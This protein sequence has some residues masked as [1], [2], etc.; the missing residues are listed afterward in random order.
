L[1]RQRIAPLEPHLKG[2]KHLLVV[3]AGKMAA[4]PIEALTDRYTVSY[5]PSASIFARRMEDHRP[6][7]ASSLL[8]LADPVFTRTAPVQ[9]TPPPHGLLVKAVL[10]GSLAARIGL[11]P[12]DVILEYD[13]K[14]LTAP[15]DLK[16][17]GGD[18]RVP[19][20][21]WREGKGMA[22]RIPQA[23]WG[24]WWTQAGRR[25]P[26][27]LAQTGRDRASAGRG[28]TWPAL[29][30]TRLE[31]RT[32]TGLVPKSTALLGSDASV[33]KLSELAA[34]GKLKDFRLLHLATHGEANAT[35]PAETALILSQDK[36]PTRLDDEA[37]AVL[38]GR[39]VPDGKLTVGTI[40]KE[41][42]LDA[43][44]VVLSAC[45]TGLG[46]QT[47]GEGMLGFTQ[48]LMQKGA[49]SVVLSPW[50]VDDAATAL[51]MAAST[52][53]CWGSE[54][55]CQPLLKPMKRAEALR[56]AKSWLR[57]LG[58]KDAAERLATLVNGVPRGERGSIKAALPTRKVE[59]SKTTDRPF[60]TRT[61]GRRSC[62]W[63][64]RS[65]GSRQQAGGR[66]RRQKV[67]PIP[68]GPPRVPH[69][70]MGSIYLQ[71]ALRD[72]RRVFPSGQ[73]LFA[74]EQAAIIAN[75]FCRARRDL[76]NGKYLEGKVYHG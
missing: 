52:R 55:G 48:A 43:D 19:V 41:W 26:G 72:K 11:L 71:L 30:G 22:G 57:G 34:A 59:E 1:H 17:A 67:P 14:K 3:P 68:L 62:C 66:G 20:K 21:L 6:L 15:A 65:E 61:T 33:Q 49:R 50:K 35:L 76:P 36:L 75:V 29:P 45:Q 51:L 37:A 16:P 46:K 13:G 39:R 63:G 18:E 9:P 56:E 60:A 70:C 5:V 31:A 53:T 8:V 32:L 74:G 4:V 44:L 27:R 40:L 10:P 23:A 73:T 58:R 12:G 38:A 28:K 42:Q 64:T 54:R 7:E 47:F 24:W 69:I 2:V 25:G